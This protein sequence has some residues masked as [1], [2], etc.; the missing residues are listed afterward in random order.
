[1]TVC[2]QDTQLFSFLRW[3][4]VALVTSWISWLSIH[5][6]KDVSKALKVSQLASIKFKGVHLIEVLL[7]MH[8][9]R[10]VHKHSVGQWLISRKGH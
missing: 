3:V 8:I 4:Q 10:S 9:F 1:M 2:W 5:I 7:Y 6:N